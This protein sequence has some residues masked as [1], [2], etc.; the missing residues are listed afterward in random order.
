MIWKLLVE[1]LIEQALFKRHER[2][3]RNEISNVSGIVT[4]IPTG[5]ILVGERSRNK[6]SQSWLG[7]EGSSS[8]F[9]EAQHEW[10]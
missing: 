6:E 10:Y 3:Y 8:K 2:Q 1:L 5:L 9:L 4:V 7:V